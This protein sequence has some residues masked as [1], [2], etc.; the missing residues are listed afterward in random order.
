MTSTSSWYAHIMVSVG[1]NLGNMLTDCTRS[2]V[3]LAR[4]G[5][6]FGLRDRFA[7]FGL[8]NLVRGLVAAGA[9]GVAATCVFVKK[10]KMYACFCH[11]DCASMD[12]RR[13][14]FTYVFIYFPI[15]LL[16]MIDT[17]HYRSSLFLFV[18]IIYSCFTDH[19]EMA[20]QLAQ[21]ASFQVLR[22][23]WGS[24]LHPCHSQKPPEY[25]LS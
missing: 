22:W 5:G 12:M 1:L 23:N 14:L 10:R 4:F 18:Y 24:M 19:L 25:F 16:C 21:V 11:K 2:L 20:K 9:V 15:W 17:F 8:I 6:R 3:V 13:G 7:V